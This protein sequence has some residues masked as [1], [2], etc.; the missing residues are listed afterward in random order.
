M[1]SAVS[2]DS[3]LRLLEAKRLMDLCSNNSGSR[4]DE[5]LENKNAILRGTF[6]VF[7]NSATL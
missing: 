3:T 6:Y 4:F 7:L 2:H 5:E 1:F